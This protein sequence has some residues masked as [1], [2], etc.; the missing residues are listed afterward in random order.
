MAEPEVEA[1]WRAEFE[2]IGETQIRETL[3]SG[4][5]F[6]DEPRRQAAFRWFGDEA[7]ARRLQE[8]QAHHYLRWSFFIAAAAVIAGLI[9]I[10]LALLD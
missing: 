1:A 6:G 4:G 9:A 2:R 3:N 8:E 10:G 5:G 7:E